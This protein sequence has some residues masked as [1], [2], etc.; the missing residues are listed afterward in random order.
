MD[1]C[2]HINV[3]IYAVLLAAETNHI[4]C[5]LS[6]VFL[7]HI[8]YKR[9]L[10]FQYAYKAVQCAFCKANPENTVKGLAVKG[11]LR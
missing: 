5:F 8:R 3:H 1:L 10:I 6:H 4:K 7:S 2:S 9:R 11:N